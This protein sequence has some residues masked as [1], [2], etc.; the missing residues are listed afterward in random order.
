MKNLILSILKFI[1]AL[2]L[3][4]TIAPLYSIISILEGDWPIIYDHY[5]ACYEKNENISPYHKHK[6]T[7]TWLR[8]NSYWH[9]VW[10]KPS[11]N[12]PWKDFRR[13]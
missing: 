5:E 8:F 12:Q 1:W 7:G 3:S 2:I 10:N 6:E 9:Y 11:I 13:L 4:T